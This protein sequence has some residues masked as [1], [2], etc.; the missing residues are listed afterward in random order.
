MKVTDFLGQEMI[1]SDLASKTKLGVLD[2]LSQ[3]VASHMTG[4][5]ADTLK[6]VLEERERHEDVGRPLVWGERRGLR[7][8]GHR[9][10]LSAF[11]AGWHRH[12]EQHGRNRLD[13]RRRSGWR[14]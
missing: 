12:P 7:G 1:V 2:E 4:V 11:A 3:H 8:A 9:A 14:L 5:D 10:G 6:R 13:N